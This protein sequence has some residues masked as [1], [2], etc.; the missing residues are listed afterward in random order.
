MFQGSTC[1]TWEDVGRRAPA[2]ARQC[3]SRL[4]GQP[5][6]GGVDRVALSTKEQY[7]PQLG[8]AGH[9]PG[10]LSVLTG[11]LAR[12]P[13]QL[14]LRL[15]KAIFSLLQQQM[16]EET[17]TLATDSR[18][19]EDLRQEALRI[20]DITSRLQD[21]LFVA[22]PSQQGP[23]QQLQQSLQDLMQQVECLYS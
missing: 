14:L 23:L 2:L 1:A 21:Q 9:P 17:G 16:E 4:D 6:P 15:D 8:Q 11:A 13:S 22:E 12:Q 10:V 5:D 7:V 3:G 18:L 19:K 20:V